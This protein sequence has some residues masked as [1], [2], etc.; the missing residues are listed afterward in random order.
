MELHDGELVADQGRMGQRRIARHLIDRRMQP[1]E[2][3]GTLQEL[4]E[5]HRQEQPQPEQRG[6]K[7][8][9]AVR[10]AGPAATG[11]VLE[12]GVDIVQ[13]G[14]RQV[15]QE[16]LPVPLEILDPFARDRL[17]RPSR[18]GLQETGIETSQVSHESGPH[19]LVELT[20]ENGTA[21]LLSLRGPVDPAPELG[22]QLMRIRPAEVPQVAAR[23]LP[24]L[25]ANLGPGIGP[26]GGTRRE[27]AAVNVGVDQ[28]QI[29]GDAR[30]RRNPGIDGEPGTGQKDDAS[31]RLGG[32]DDR[33]DGLRLRL[34]RAF[35]KHHRP[36]LPGKE[37]PKHPR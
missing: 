31:P 2:V 33:F 17:P 16:G 37:T 7:G 15:G 11:Q 26:V 8:Q 34:R 12:Q 14:V 28:G 20:P 10:D 36:P 19:T 13:V 18:C 5:V 32:F 21:G 9:K 4:V 29:A 30:K 22:F 1:F 23:V 25:L 24:V 35:P 6:Q 3:Q 27:D